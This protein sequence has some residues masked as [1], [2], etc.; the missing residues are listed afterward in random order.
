[1]DTVLEVKNLK[2]TF[3]KGKQPYTAVSN[4][5]FYV[6]KG[7]CLGLVGESGC[8][9][10]TTA[11]MIAHLERADEGE[12]IIGGKSMNQ[13]KGKE[14]K[15]LY[16]NIQMVFQ[17]PVDSFNPR[18]HLGTAIMESMINH[19]M[20]RKN[21]SMRMLELLELCGLSKEYAKRYPHQVSGG[22]CQRAAIARAIAINPDLLIC[23]EATSALDVTVQDQIIRL[24]KKLQSELKM[25]YLF[26]CHDLALVQQICDRVLVMHEGEIVEE[27]TPDEVIRFPKEDYTKK[28]V[29]S[30]FNV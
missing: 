10:S 2:K 25:S 4:V 22:E 24:L 14:L 30:V 16:C 3:Y 29:E 17:S 5:S 6:G 12:I 8:G 21:A 27:G 18:M 7:E 26:I 1:M 13:A 20:T 23:D 11:N 9:K 19:G 15:E 28:L